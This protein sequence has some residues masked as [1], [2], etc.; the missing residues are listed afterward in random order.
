MTTEAKHLRPVANTGKGGG[1]SGRRLAG[2]KTRHPETREAALAELVK[3]LGGYEAAAEILGLK[4]KSTLQAYTDPHNEAEAPFRVVLAATMATRNPVAA[5]LLA[6]A[7]G[8]MVIPVEPQDGCLLT[9]SAMKAARDGETMADIMQG[10][11]DGVY[12]PEEARAVLPKARDSL[13][14]M[15]NVYAL[16]LQIIEG[17]E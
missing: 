13:Q 16:L 10:L 7:A 9:L 14:V 3:D 2:Y 11:A 5:T 4:S 1:F 12:T 17:A 15:A 6:S 8:G